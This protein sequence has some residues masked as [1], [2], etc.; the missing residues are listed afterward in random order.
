MV[1]N[2]YIFLLLYLC[3]SSKRAYLQALNLLISLSHPFPLMK[4]PYLLFTRCLTGGLLLLASCAKNNEQITPIPPTIG[5][6]SV[7]VLQ[8]QFLAKNYAPQ[9][10]FPLK[11]HTSIQLTPQWEHLIQRAASTSQRAASTSAAIPDVYVPLESPTLT[12][13]GVKDYLLIHQEG[14]KV[15]F[16]EASYLF[17]ATQNPAKDAVNP[18]D[19]F[20]SF[21]GTLRVRKL[22]TGTKSYTFYKT[23]VLQAGPSPSS[24]A[25][26]RT[27]AT[28]GCYTVVECRWDGNCGL[29]ECSAHFGT[30]TS[31]IDYCDSPTED[32]PCCSQIEWQLTSSSTQLFCDGGGDDSGGSGGGSTSSTTSIQDNAAYLVDNPL[33][34]FGPCPGLN[35]KWKRQITF[36]PSAQIMQKI[37]GL[38]FGTRMNLGGVPVDWGYYVQSIGNASGALVNL[39]FHYMYF[40]SLPVIDG[41][42]TTLNGFADYLRLNLGGLTGTPFTPSTHTGVDES[43]LWTHSVV[44]TVLEIGIPGDPGAVICSEY[45]RAGPGNEASWV[46]TT[47]HD[48]YVG[49][50]PVSGTRFFGLQD[51][52]SGYLFYTQ[53]ADRLTGNADAFAAW[54]TGLSNTANGIQFT[55]A[56]AL[57]EKAMGNVG[58]LLDPNNNPYSVGTPTENRP[59]FADVLS[60]IQNGRPLSTVPCN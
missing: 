52:G 23:G 16:S 14:G 1:V 35:D 45:N 38:N 18:L 36:K 25:S 47:I 20:A 58:L 9:L 51:L 44:G 26:K 13:V 12:W 11:N 21:T 54:L 29:H 24:N 48:P 5:Q 50:H 34:L 32:G 39:D 4:L 46:F 53:G 7:Q 43:Y 33:A 8:Q 27:N 6:A 42:Q 2:L 22:A 56:D 57:W 15:E 31:G 60:A 30:I 59:K 55:S 17:K 37:S 28:L 40:K 41:Q 3:L 49:D 19:F 10:V